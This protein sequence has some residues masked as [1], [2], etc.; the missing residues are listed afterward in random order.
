MEP[1]RINGIIANEIRV[2]YPCPRI[3]EAYAEGTARAI[4]QTHGQEPDFDLARYRALMDVALKCSSFAMA[5][6][7]GTGLPNR[8]N[9]P[10]VDHFLRG[11]V[12]LELVHV[13]EIGISA[14]TLERVRQDRERKLFLD[15]VAHTGTL[16]TRAS[17]NRNRTGH[18]E[19][20]LEYPRKCLKFFLSDGFLELQAIELEQ[21]PFK[22]GQTPMGTKI[23]L[24]DV[25]VIKGIAYLRRHNV[26]EV[27]GIVEEL[28]NKHRQR[29]YEELDRRM[30]EETFEAIFEGLSP[31]RLYLSTQLEDDR[32][33]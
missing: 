11:P 30:N 15:R 24:T 13:T 3:K 23:R 9:E 33:E 31:E 25:P 29:L 2:A 4:V 1:F 10:K 26:L 12:I 32:E 21:L 27:G 19:L 20:Q 8:I 18:G 14:F 16:E 7:P 5:A 17:C 6:I 28:Q 22:L